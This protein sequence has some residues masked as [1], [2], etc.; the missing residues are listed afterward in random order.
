MDCTIHDYKTGKALASHV[1]VD[2]DILQTFAQWP[3][4]ILPAGKLLSAWQIQEIQ[5]SGNPDFKASTIVFC[6]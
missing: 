3:E 2:P 4:G 1:E 6:Q 5:N